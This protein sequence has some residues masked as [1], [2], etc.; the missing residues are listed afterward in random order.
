MIGRARQW[1]WAS[2]RRRRRVTWLALLLVISASVASLVVWVR[3]TGR[4][5]VAPLLPGKVQNYQE[6]K[7]VRL[8][9]TA[10]H[11]AE[12]TTY[13]FLST[14]VVREH[15]E[16]SYDL[17]APSLRA[18]MSR[19]DWAKGENSIIPYPVDLKT[20]RYRVD[21]S[22]AASPPD[23]LPLIGMTVSVKPHKGA[24]QAA[25]DFGIEL[26]AAGK[27]PRRHWLVSSWEPRGQLGG[28]PQ[29][30]PRGAV[31]QEPPRHGSLSAAW[32]LIPAGILSAIVLI[33]V[34]L[35]VRGWRRHRR[36]ARDYTRKLEL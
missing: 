20:V 23:G 9:P 21:Y 4:K 7:K 3:D 12:V 24:Q 25:M 27:G 8:T 34:S 18:G 17:V 16:N 2:R 36:V 30:A 19:A 35:G 29:N 33:P 1:W 32:L 6:P 10:L 31:R 14:A 26:E 22:Y 11:A 15:V 5:S 28:E 13:V